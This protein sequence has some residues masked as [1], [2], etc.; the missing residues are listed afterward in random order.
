MLNAG[1]GTVVDMSKRAG[2]TRDAVFAT[3]M[4]GVFKPDPAVYHMAAWPIIGEGWRKC[5]RR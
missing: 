5:A 1:M 4:A 2:L 3:E